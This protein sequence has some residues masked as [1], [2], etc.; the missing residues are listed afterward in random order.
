MARFIIGTRLEYDHL[1]TSLL[2][3]ILIQ[4]LLL[5]NINYFTCRFEAMIASCQYEEN[6]QNDRQGIK[7]V[8]NP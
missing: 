7:K 2:V 3:R 1:L 4:F 6:Q 8:S 5:I